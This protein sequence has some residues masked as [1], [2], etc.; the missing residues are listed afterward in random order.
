VRR[1]I[2]NIRC[3]KQT[4]VFD[5]LVEEGEIYLELK[6]S[7]NRLLKIPWKDVVYQVDALRYDAEKEFNN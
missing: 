1:Q 4:R 2:R 3:Q 5:A 7:K 6:T